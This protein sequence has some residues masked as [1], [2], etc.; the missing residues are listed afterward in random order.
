MISKQFLKSSLIYS[1]VGALP[2]VSGIVLIPFFT[3]SLSTE[4][5][6]ANAL[7]FSFL[8]FIQ[9]ISTF[10]LDFYVGVHYFDHKENPKK[11]G[12]MM[13]TTLVSLAIIAIFILIIL[14]LFG[15]RIFSLAFRDASLF[16]FFPFGFFTVITAI[17]SGFFKT[18]TNLLVNQQRP[19]RFFWLNFT[20]FIMVMTFSLGLLWIF[21]F[22]LYGPIMGR[23]FPAVISFIIVMI[24]MIR[25]FRL[26]WSSDLIRS[27]LSFCFPLLI[28]GLAIWTVNYIDRY[29]IY[30]FINDTAI[31]GIYD[32]AVKITLTIEFLQI[33]LNSS[34]QP[35][36]FNLWKESGKKESTVEMNR[37]YNGLTGATILVIP[38]LVLFVPLLVPFVINKPVYYQAFAFIPVLSL[39]FATRGWFYMFISP[40]FYFKKT[41]VLP[42]VFLISA[43]IQIIMTTLLIKYYFIWG[44]VFANLLI[45]PIQ[46]AILYTE[47]RKVFTFRFNRW[48]TIYMPVIFIV[49][50]LVLQYFSNDKNRIVIGGIQ[51]IL[52]FILVFAV[53]RREL[54]P[55][56]RKWR[57]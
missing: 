40:L 3:N 32:F 4:Q 30:Y 46:A 27:I 18:Y 52:T 12:Q 29:I 33:G 14:F 34:I 19:E 28:Y 2:Y 49:G 42:K 6:G 5:F 10:S 56:L 50:F 17:L 47:S 31:V 43:V 54:L 7:Y 24:M 41:K 21:P 13:G 25:E 55:L 37:Y 53:Y 35:K 9:I 16:R 11:L 45:K 26:S 38:L 1:V 44:A 51:V 36:I 20:N 48:K 22:T 39:G 23:L 8:Y 15:T 57:G